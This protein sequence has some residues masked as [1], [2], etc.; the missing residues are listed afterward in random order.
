M[1]VGGV[2]NLSSWTTPQERAG[3]GGGRGGAVWGAQG[4]VEE[5][6]EASLVLFGRER[7]V[8]ERVRGPE[9]CAARRGGDD[10]HPQIAR[11][12]DDGEGIGRSAG[13]LTR[14]RV[15]PSRDGEP[16]VNERVLVCVA[17]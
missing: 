2:G 8:G 5:L 11:V 10:V 1:R 3:R 14:E 4:E 16:V 13:G 6:E 9:D 12:E 15:E 17:E 7:R